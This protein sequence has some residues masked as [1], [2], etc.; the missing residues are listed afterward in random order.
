MN[1]KVVLITDKKIV[2]INKWP[3][4]FKVVIEVLTAAVKRS[5]ETVSNFSAA[6]ATLKKQRQ[7]PNV[8]KPGVVLRKDSMLKRK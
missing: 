4:R 8:A 6:L 5:T 3:D 1:K 2:E 7:R